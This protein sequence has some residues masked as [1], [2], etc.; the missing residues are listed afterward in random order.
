VSDNKY[1]VV[2]AGCGGMANAWMK[3]AME[4]PSVKIVGLV[5]IRHEAAKALAE[6]YNLPAEIAGTSI[7]DA[8]LRGNA[9]LVFD[10]TIPAAHH[11]VVMAALSNGCHVLG[12]K[13]LSDSMSCAREMV[14]AAQKANRQYAVMQ[15][16]RFD[17]NIRAVRKALVE[18]KAVGAVEE[19]HGDF[20]IGAH[21]GGFRD[22]MDDVLIVD[23]A[24]HSFDQA[25]YISG[26]DPVSVYCH[27][28]NPGHSWY[29][30]N[31]SATCIFEMSN[32]VVYTYRGSW[33]AEGLQTSWECSWRVVCEKGTLLWNG[34]SEIRAQKVKEG[35]KHAFMSEMEDVPVAIEPLAHTGH[36]GLIRDF[37]DCLDTGR[38]P[39][40]TAADNIKSLAMVMAAV[41]SSKT[42]QKVPITV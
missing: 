6:K 28:S 2:L 35:G 36:A 11:E 14:A 9:N 13:P 4:L 33:C 20:F 18:D 19:V 38:T 22:L 23:M 8:I 26:C 41:E 24:I 25:R 12:E 27:A 31:A 32:G 40:T 39:L 29:K 37:I 15:N 21:F 10:V 3:T 17:P 7:R 30:G 5:D 16:R 34:A 42:G 1:N